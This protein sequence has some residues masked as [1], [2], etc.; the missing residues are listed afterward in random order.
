MC[1][2]TTILFLG[3]WLPPLDIWP[4]N[5]VPG[6]FWFLI[7]VVMVF[8]MFA[9]V[10]AIVPRYRY[11]QLMRLGWKIFLPISLV[12]VIL[13]QR[14]CSSG[15]RWLLVEVYVMRLDQGV[16]SFFLTEFVSAFFLTMRYFF[17]PKKTINYPHEKRP[18]VA[19]LPR[20]ACA[21]PLSERRRTLHRL[22]AVRG[23]LPGAGD[24]DR[25]RSAPQ[26]RHA[27]HDALRHR[28]GEV[29]L[30]RLSA[31]RPARSTPSSK[32]RT[33]S[34]PKRARSSTTQGAPARER[35]AL[36]TRDRRNIALDAPYR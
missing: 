31:R 14:R 18:A 1:A 22:Q 30:L 7:K 29:H 36:G 8:F 20:R 35:R 5:V 4:L 25:S 3:G 33:N 26:R 16:K 32:A 2:L 27:P 17:K 24:H 6:I 19:A 11:D 28:H 15:P 34:R 23:D 13:T 9:M 21:A 12:M 10:K